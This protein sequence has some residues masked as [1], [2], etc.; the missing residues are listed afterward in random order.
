MRTQNG[1]PYNTVGIVGSF[2][3]HL[4]EI[5]K[6]HRMF[7]DAG[8]K[9][10]APRVIRE[11]VDPTAEFVLFE[12]EKDD[13]VA[14]EGGYQGALL[15]SDAVVCCNPNGYIG[16]SVMLELG[17]LA[18]ERRAEVYFT[19]PPAEP[20]INAMAKKVLSIVSVEELIERMTGHNEVLSWR[21]WPDDDRSAG[22]NFS[23]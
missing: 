19:D 11:V 14:L 18:G 4:P 9:V 5:T 17:R 8:F 1:D 3:R 13:P 21:E 15:E 10:L 23:L 2:R 20:V 12:G 22:T 16:G 6:A 7:T